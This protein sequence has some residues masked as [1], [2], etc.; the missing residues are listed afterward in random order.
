MLLPFRKG[1]HS[2]AAVGHAHFAV[3]HIRRLEQA[4]LLVQYSSRGQGRALFRGR[5]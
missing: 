1:G 2:L 5:L 4:L 3:H